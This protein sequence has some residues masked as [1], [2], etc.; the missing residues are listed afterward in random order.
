MRMFCRDNR[1]LTPCQLEFVNAHL[2]L[3]FIGRE[4]EFMVELNSISKLIFDEAMGRLIIYT[5]DSVLEVISQNIEDLDS[6][7]RILA[8]VSISESLSELDK[9][10][11]Y[12]RTF[13]DVASGI[14]ELVLSLQEVDARGGINWAK[15]FEVASKVNDSI[16]MLSSKVPSLR[17]ESIKSLM[18]LI[19]NRYIKEILRSA[20]AVLTQVYDASRSG[21]AGVIPGTC[22][23]ILLDLVLLYILKSAAISKRIHIS[24]RGFASISEESEVT[25]TRYARVFG[26]RESHIAK[27]RELIHNGAVSVGEFIDVIIS[28]LRS[29]FAESQPG[30]RSK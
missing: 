19:E 15:I 17:S 7:S 20:K 22:P 27:I 14:I 24:E 26:V 16:S 25:L 11:E 28:A 10:A 6:V 4:K 30:R 5:R 21:L 1:A 13:S 18:N 3:R 29:S 2:I 12:L 8:R 9:I 23:E